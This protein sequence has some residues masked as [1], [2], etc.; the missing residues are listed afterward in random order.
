M[1]TTSTVPGS[2]TITKA[3]KCT[4][5]E[6][7]F[8][9]LKIMASRPEYYSAAAPA[10]GTELAQKDLE[11][12]ELSP[13]EMTVAQAGINCLTTYGFVHPKVGITLRMFDKE[14]KGKEQAEN[15]NE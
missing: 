6:E 13:D 2:G 12:F 15:S 10:I 14:N 5:K 4:T 8:S 1:A 7:L 9:I 11:S 3:K